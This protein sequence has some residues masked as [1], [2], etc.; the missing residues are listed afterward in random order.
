MPGSSTWLGTSHVCQNSLK[1]SGIGFDIAEKYLLTAEA[2]ANVD[3][4]KNMRL[5]GSAIGA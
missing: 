4:T 1:L 5:N 2:I 3:K